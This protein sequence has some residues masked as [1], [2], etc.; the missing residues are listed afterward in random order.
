MNPIF[1]VVDELDRWQNAERAQ[2]RKL[3]LVIEDEIMNGRPPPSLAIRTGW[4]PPGPLL[5]GIRDME[6]DVARLRRYGLQR[7][8]S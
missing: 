3:E 7:P 6:D 4:T 8:R 2:G 1:V 5:P